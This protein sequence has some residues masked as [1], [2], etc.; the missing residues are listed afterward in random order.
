MYS[1][2]GATYFRQEKRQI[3]R[4]YIN[5]SQKYEC[6]NWD[7]EHYDSVLGITVS[8]LGIHRWEPDIY[9]RFSTELHLQCVH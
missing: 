2:D 4:G 7:T 3:D 9:I 5:L 6:R 1:Q 8:F